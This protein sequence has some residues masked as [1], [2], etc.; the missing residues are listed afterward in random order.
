MI[1]EG[2]HVALCELF[3]TLDELGCRVDPCGSRITC[4]P[5]P[6][7][8]DWDFLVEV[9]GEAELS[10]AVSA[11]SDAEFIWEGSEHYQK[12]AAEGFMSFRSVENINL[13]VTANSAFAIR[14]RAATILCTRLNVLNKQDRIAIFQA[15]LYGN[16][17]G[18]GKVLRFFS[19][20]NP[21]GRELRGLEKAQDAAGVAQ[22]GN[23]CSSATDVAVDSEF[24]RPAPVS[25]DSEEPP[26]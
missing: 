22:G 23:S 13:I 3:G 6:E 11:I 14:H 7:G 5:I 20:E 18:D 1:S 9:P 19:D 17:W 24:G 21:H 10:Q 16:V 15:V 2:F 25:V 4:A 8:S 26:F 12:I